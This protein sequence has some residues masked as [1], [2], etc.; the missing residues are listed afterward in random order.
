MHTSVCYSCSNVG[1]RGRNWIQCVQSL[2]EVLIW[3]KAICCTKFYETAGCRISITNF[4]SLNAWNSWKFP[5]CAH[6]PSFHSIPL[7]ISSRM[8][9][10]ALILL[11][12]AEFLSFLTIAR[13][14]QHYSGFAVK[15]DISYLQL[16]IF[17]A[18]KSNRN[19][20]SPYQVCLWTGDRIQYSD[21]YQVQL[22]NLAC[23][24]W[25]LSDRILQLGDL[26]D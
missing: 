24:R 20:S 3:S 13:R 22:G 16:N 7:P 8:T 10:Q 14:G 12:L 17:I 5:S 11:K 1:S 9:R 6:C 26:V 2:P 19:A 25:N 18:A 4:I 15:G 23:S 21:N